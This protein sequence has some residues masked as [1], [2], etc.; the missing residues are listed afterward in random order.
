MLD[1]AGVELENTEVV[2]MITDGE[3]AGLRGAKQW[4]KDHYE[5]YCNSGVETAPTQ[6][7]MGKE[8]EFRAITV[9]VVSILSLFAVLWMLFLEIAT[10]A[11]EPPTE[12]YSHEFPAYTCQ[13]QKENP[14]GDTRTTLCT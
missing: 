6:Q 5:E 7:S 11:T 9:A 8:Q 10:G 14:A 1:M 13:L 2:C 12:A 4:S 3:E